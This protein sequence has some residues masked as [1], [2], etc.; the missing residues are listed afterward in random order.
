MKKYFKFLL[1]NI[2]LAFFINGAE[3]QTKST[4]KKTNQ[5]KTVTLK[6]TSYKPREF[7]TQTSVSQITDLDATSP[8]YES[9]KHLIENSGVTIAYNDNTFKGKE[10][11]HRGDFIVALNSAF[12]NIKRALEAAGIDSSVIN[13]YDRNRNG[14]YLTTIEQVK[15]VPA[16]SYYYPAAKSLLER[17]GVGAPFTLTKTLNPTSTISEK[18]VYD[19][20]KATLGYVSAG[21]NPYSTAMTR[22]KFAIVLNNAVGQKMTAVNSMITTKKLAADTERRQQEL[23]MQQQEATRK[24]SIAKEIELRKVEAAKQE[25]EARKKLADKNKK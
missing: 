21:A 23:V 11:L 19:I 4:A 7:G 10:P 20:L 2:S 13:T 22:E 3:A 5:S 24:D 8:A 25:A 9:V 16:T 12:V 18:E 1:I 6:T 15:D 17:W 14:S